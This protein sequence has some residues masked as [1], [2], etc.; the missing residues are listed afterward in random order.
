MLAKNGS[1]KLGSV[2]TGSKQRDEAGGRVAHRNLTR[3]LSQNRT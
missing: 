1:V 3:T 2:Q